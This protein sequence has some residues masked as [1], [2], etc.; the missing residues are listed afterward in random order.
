MDILVG[1]AKFSPLFLAIAMFGMGLSMKL[2]DFH[3]IL[4]N[5][6]Q[7]LVGLLLQVILLPAIGFVLALVFS[8]EP[9]LAIGLMLLAACPGGPGSNLV[10]FLSKGD[11][12]LSI[13]LTSCSSVLAIISVP[14]IVSFSLS[15][16]QAQSGVAF[17]IAHL[18]G[19]IL[20][21]T[22]VPVSL[23][24]FTGLKASSFAARCEKGIKVLVFIFIVLLVAAT[25]LK[26]IETITKMISTLGI[27]LMTFAI[28]AVAVSF[29]VT[30]LMGFSSSHQTTIAIEAGLQNPVLAVFVASTFLNT[31]EFAIPAMVYPV[32]MLSISLVFIISAQ[33]QKPPLSAEIL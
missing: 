31:T 25:I 30:R 32:V 28:I 29:F 13:A 22:L 17:S 33:L 16:F 6:K 7:V 2:S 9:V 27:P 20:V 8:L 14:L 10:S 26:E 5:K 19:M 12:A 15:Y 24:I 18:V 3:Y 1:L 23:G 21:V 11:V 4:S